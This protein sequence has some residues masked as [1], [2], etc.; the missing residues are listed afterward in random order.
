[1]VGL[2]CSILVEEEV[3]YGFLIWCLGVVVKIGDVFFS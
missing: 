2:V 1:M 3:E